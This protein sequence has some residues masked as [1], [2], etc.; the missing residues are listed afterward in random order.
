MYEH[1]DFPT[2][3]ENNHRSRMAINQPLRERNRRRTCVTNDYRVWAES[4]KDE[5]WIVEEE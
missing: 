4:E 1:V 3:E 2:V 5:D